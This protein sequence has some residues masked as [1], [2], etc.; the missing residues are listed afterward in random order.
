MICL[1][2]RSDDTDLVNILNA[3]DRSFCKDLFLTFYYTPSDL[4]YEINSC[5][6]SHRSADIYGTC[7]ELV[8]KFGVGN[9][10]PVH[11]GDHLTAVHEGTHLF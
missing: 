4:I 10:V 1:V 8:G 5:G 3:C 6:K 11:D 7:F 2:L 9:P